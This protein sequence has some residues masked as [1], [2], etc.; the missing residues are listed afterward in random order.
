MLANINMMMMNYHSC[1]LTDGTD[2]S[3]FQ[4]LTL[5][6]ISFQFEFEFSVFITQKGD[7]AVK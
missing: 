4:L 2:H 3:E 6:I 1:H 5:K 7:C